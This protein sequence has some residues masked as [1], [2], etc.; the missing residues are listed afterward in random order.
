MQNLFE[1]SS[2]SY[3][4][5][6][7]HARPNPLMAKYPELCRVDRSRSIE[8]YDLKP[9]ID[10]NVRPI[11]KPLR[12][13]P[14]GLEEQVGMKLAE[15]ESARLLEKIDSPPWVS[16]V[17]VVPK[18]NGDFRLCLDSRAVKTPIIPDRYPLPPIE[19]LSKVFD[20][21]CKFTNLN[22]KPGYWEIE[23]HRSSRY[24]SAIITPKGLYQ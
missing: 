1:L 24:L 9:N 13:I 3:D 15:L 4:G 5:V 23:F 7:E 11:A 10:P 18:P 20:G 8:G 21:G 2:P 14:L 6:V 22:L 17:V 16:N 19:E 12:R